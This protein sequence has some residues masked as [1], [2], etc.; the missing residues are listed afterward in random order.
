MDFGHLTL[1]RK[2]KPGDTGQ[3]VNLLKEA[4]VILLKYIHMN[5]IVYFQ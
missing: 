2:T 4:K 1:K 5:L 3:Q